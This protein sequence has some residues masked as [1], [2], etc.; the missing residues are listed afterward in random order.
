LT[1]LRND[2]RAIFRAATAAS[3]KRTDP[4]AHGHARAGHCRL[5]S[6]RRAASVAL[7][8]RRKDKNH[9]HNCPIDR[10]LPAE[11]G[12]GSVAPAAVF[13]LYGESSPWLQRS[14]DGYAVA[15]FVKPGPVPAPW[16]KGQPSARVP[17]FAW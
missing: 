8:I 16:R 5:T 10:D 11:Y 2:K 17:R 6:S 4:F 14:G 3:R 7:L 13:R 1:A 15:L 9:D 12:G